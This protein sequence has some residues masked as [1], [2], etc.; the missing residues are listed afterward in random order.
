MASLTIKV[1]QKSGVATAD[2]AGAK[3]ALL[4]Y[5]QAYEGPVNGTDQEQLDWI[6]D[7]LRRHINDVA[8][9]EENRQEEA[10]ARQN[11]KAT[12]TKRFKD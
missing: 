7:H 6:A 9:A 2:N 11:V 5:L 12:S 3:D 8:E 10:A 1:G 4:L